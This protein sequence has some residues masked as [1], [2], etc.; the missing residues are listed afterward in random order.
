MRVNPQTGSFRQNWDYRGGN[1]KGKPGFDI[2]DGTW[3]VLRGGSAGGDVFGEGGAVFIQGRAASNLMAWNDTLIV[4]PSY[5]ITREKAEMAENKELFDFSSWVNSWAKPFPKEEASDAK[6]A[7]KAP[8]AQSLKT[9]AGPKKGRFPLKD[10]DYLWKTKDTFRGCQVKALVLAAN[11]ALYAGRKSGNAGFE[12]PA[13][14]SFLCA[15][16]L[17]DGK[18]HSEITLDCPPIYDGL[19]VAEEKVFLSLQNGMLVCFGK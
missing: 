13:E 1:S 10:E 6:P 14:K 18:K 17:A 11:A 16:S 19:A 8:Q 9:G 12:T 2:L 15:F 7:E 4:T 5:I 3:T